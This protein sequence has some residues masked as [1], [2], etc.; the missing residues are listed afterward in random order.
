[1]CTANLHAHF[2]HTDHLENIFDILVLEKKYI[3]NI[4]KKK[5]IKK[6]KIKNKVTA[7]HT[8]ITSLYMVF[9]GWL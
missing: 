7:F 3:A 1:M 8:C 9:D 6:E 4:I 5:K 2:T